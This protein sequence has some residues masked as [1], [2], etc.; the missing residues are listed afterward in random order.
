LQLG[1]VRAV[2]V[3][4]QRLQ[5]SPV[6]ASRAVA[7]SG[8][9]ECFVNVPKI[10]LSADS[11]LIRCVALSPLPRS[12][13]SEKLGARGLIPCGSFSEKSLLSASCGLEEYAGIHER[14]TSQKC[15]VPASN[16]GVT[17]CK[18]IFSP[19]TSTL[20]RYQDLVI[21]VVLLRESAAPSDLSSC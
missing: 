16:R 1:A 18:E 19:S 13:M 7:T 14:H 3:F 15:L 21:N 6:R 17:S 12:V 5:Y 20:Q 10:S 2:C 8:W 4:S 11:S 9:P